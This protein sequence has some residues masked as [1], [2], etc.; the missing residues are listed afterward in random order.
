MYEIPFHQQPLSHKRFLITGGAG[1]I[2]SNLVEYLLRH[3]AGKVR[4]LDNLSTGDYRNI[5]AFIGSPQLEWIE[6][7]IT[8]ADTCFKAA[9]GIDIV[10]HQAAL[11][12]VPRSID[13][14]LATNAAN[15][16]G[17]LNV[18]VAAKE[19]GVQRVV[20]AASSSVYGDS[21]ILPKTEEIVGRPLSPYA[22]SKYINELYA[23]VFGRVYGLESIGLRYFNVYGPRQSP[24]GA[25]AAVIPRFIHAALA[26]QSPEIHGDGEQTRDFTFIENVVQANI[27]AALTENKE[28]L[29]QVYNIACGAS[30]SLNQLWQMLQEATQGA[31]AARYVAARQGDVR[32]S[33]ADIS[34]AEK[35]LDYRPQVGMR[36]GLLRTLEWFQN[37]HFFKS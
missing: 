32:H 5:E 21:P 7:D 25:Y 31:V 33:L 20:Y 28:A 17:F 4:V 19:Q 23:E 9:E 13:N 8:N 10:L 36:E 27:K 11:G 3:G 1:F 6:G 16:S 2:G 22:L 26:G 18:L 15:V 37:S 35:H 29:Q 14:P 34:K 24:A 12:S 30:S